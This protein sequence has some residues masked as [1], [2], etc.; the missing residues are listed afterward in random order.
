LVGSITHLVWDSFTHPDGWMV[1]RLPIFTTVIFR[2]AGS[3][4]QIYKLL[5]YASSF[6]GMAVIIWWVCKW[7]Q[8]ARP[9]PGSESVI[10]PTFGKWIILIS[11]LGIATGL[12][13]WASWLHSPEIDSLYRLR[14]FA[15]QIFVSGTSVFCVESIVFGLIWKRW[16]ETEAKHA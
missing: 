16:V 5:Q 15:A 1:E 9:V 3:D 8:K 14:E 10:I 12:A 6:L 4:F 7:Y 13:V 11:M 2:L